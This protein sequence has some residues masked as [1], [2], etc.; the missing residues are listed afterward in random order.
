MTNKDLYKKICT[1]HKGIRMFMQPWWLDVVCESWDVAIA[2]RGMS[3][4]G[5]GPTLLKIN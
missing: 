3:L 4:P 1:E 5:Y 2:K